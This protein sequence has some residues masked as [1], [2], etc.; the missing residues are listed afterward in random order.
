MN[1]IS[2]GTLR[3]SDLDVLMAICSKMREKGT[4][5][6]ELSFGELRQ[7]AELS[8]CDSR[9]RF[10]AAINSV[11]R[12][13]INIVGHIETDDEDTFFTL[14]NELSARK[15]EGIVRV[16]INPKYSFV[17][18]DLQ[19]NFTT[20]ELKEFTQLKSKYSKNLYRLLKQ[21]TKPD[22]DSE[23]W[24]RF[25]AEDLRE[26]LGC[27]KSYQNKIF[28]RDIL[29]PCIEELS[30]IFDGLTMD[31]TKA[32]RQGS[33]ISGYEFRW[34]ATV[35]DDMPGQGELP[36]EKPKFK[37]TAFHNIENADIDFDEL[38]K[39]LLQK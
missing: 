17:L 27:P 21:I 39:N 38:E 18:N 10:A 19:T 20:F 23:C 26:K 33:P 15:K 2:L 24:R 29:L 12:K 5:E 1:D 14:F 6:V 11:N 9:E 8:N 34:R 36:I 32:R 28:V 35:D 3:A 22:I 37:K 13:L 4:E 30:P 31:I 16:S 25:K 7:I